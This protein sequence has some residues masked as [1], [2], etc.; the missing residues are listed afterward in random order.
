MMQ[1]LSLR[2]VFP[3]VL[4]AKR[5]MPEKHVRMMLSKKEISELRKD[6][7]DIYKRNMVNRHMVRLKDSIFEHLCYAL[8]LNVIS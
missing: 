4:F 1:E 5:N 2:K 7:T 3:G 8:S 6:N